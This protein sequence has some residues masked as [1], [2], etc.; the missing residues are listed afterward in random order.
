MKV[1]ALE[2]SSMV[3]A[4]AI[5]DE[6]KLIAEYILNHKKNHS[7]KLMPLVEEVMESAEL[8]P[9]DIDV[10]AVAHGPGSFTGLRI[11]VSTVKALAQ[12]SG[13]PVV[14]VSTLDALAFN[15]PFCD[16]LIC[17]ILDARREQVYTSVYRWEKEQLQRIDEYMAIPVDELIQRLK[18]KSEKILFNGDGVFVYRDI[19][20]KELRS[21]ACFAPPT[22]ALQRASSVAWLG[23][24]KALKGETQSYLNLEP[25]YIRKSQAE[26]RLEALCAVKE[27]QA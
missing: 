6:Y 14:G 24:Q 18:S 27:N 8:T 10:Y 21:S 11:G 20:M 4:A 12:A 16:G 3:A 25:F 2:S 19:I 9:Q 5:V 22:C 17:P 1:L 7:Q 13:K 26:Q 15:L 23:L